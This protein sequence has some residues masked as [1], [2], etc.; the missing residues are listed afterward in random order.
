M[1]RTIVVLAVFGAGLLAGMAWKWGPGIAR[2]DG[3]AVAT[4]NG[5]VDGSGG[6]D[7]TDAI[8]LLRHLF[9][10]GPTPVD[11]D[12]APAGKAVVR[13]LTDL[14][15]FD[16]P[17][18]AT[19]AIGGTALVQE[20]FSDWGSCLDVEPETDGLARI[21]VF[22]DCGPL[23]FESRL[24]IQEGHTY[25]VVLSVDDFGVFVIW[26]DQT[27]DCATPYPLPEDLPAGELPVCAGGGASAPDG[28]E[29]RSGLWSR[30]R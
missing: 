11:F 4:M 17:V 18:S 23:C 30:R 6:L 24:A 26:Y 3:G 21:T 25:S 29:A 15:C 7:L 27:G 28:L 8:Y 19:L 10:G 22:S 12:C 2:G 14:T 9:L 1:R 5:D 13:L 16:A 20:A